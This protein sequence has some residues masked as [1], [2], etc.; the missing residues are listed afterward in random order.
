[1]DPPAEEV[2]LPKDSAGKVGSW[3]LLVDISATRLRKITLLS[4]ACW[5]LFWVTSPWRTLRTPGLLGSRRG[6]SGVISR[7]C[8]HLGRSSWLHC[9]GG[10]LYKLSVNDDDDEDVID[11]TKARF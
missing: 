5:S 3:C 11:D 7:L 8:T 2:P 1:M 6:S 9:Q 10:A 4:T